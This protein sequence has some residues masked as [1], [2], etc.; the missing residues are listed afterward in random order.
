MVAEAP[1]A[2]P[3][4]EHRDVFSAFSEVRNRYLA[5]AVNGSRPYALPAARPFLGQAVTQAAGCDP[6]VVAMLAVVFGETVARGVAAGREDMPAVGSTEAAADRF[7]AAAAPAATAA[8]FRVAGAILQ[9]YADRAMR[10]AITFSTEPGEELAGEDRGG[11]R[12]VTPPA[13]A[14][15]VLDEALNF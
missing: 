7:L 1:A 2:A 11:S 6:W 13:V 3:A 9:G 10:E 4:A 14:G 8:F 12:P 5:L 15:A